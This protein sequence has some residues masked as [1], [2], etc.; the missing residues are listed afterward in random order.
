MIKRRSNEMKLPKIKIPGVKSKKEAKEI[1][2]RYERKVADYIEFLVDDYDFDYGSLIRMMIYKMKR[3]RDHILEH[4]YFEG[5][6][7]VAKQIKT[8]IDLLTRVQ[9]DVY[10][11][12]VF[13]KFYKKHGRPKMVYGKKTEEGNY[14]VE[15]I[16]SNGKPATEEMSKEMQSLYKLE[17]EA[18]QSDL[19][20]AFQ[21][22]EQNILGWWC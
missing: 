20:L 10:H 3:L 7:K 22:M 11:D 2:A 15:F 6:K 9:E 16:Y 17:G 13:A 14:P 19:R 12:E 4:K 5:Y 21:N 8:S 1:Q 18:K